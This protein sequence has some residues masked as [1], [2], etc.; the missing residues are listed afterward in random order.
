MLR[1]IICNFETVSVSFPDHLHPATTRSKAFF[2][3]SFSSRQC[4]SRCILALAS[5]RPHD[6]V[7]ASYEPPMEDK[8]M[9]YTH[10]ML[11]MRLADRTVNT[12]RHINTTLSHHAFILVL[13][14]VLVLVSSRL[15]LTRT[16][17]PFIIQSPKVAPSVSPRHR[18]PPV[19]LSLPDLSF[20]Q[21]S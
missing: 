20:G 2:P 13:V 7:D 17:H 16:P 14:L 5:N 6:H 10:S 3:L 9:L 18:I 15:T 8:E 11:A 4:I 19:R 12:S 21:D 1:K